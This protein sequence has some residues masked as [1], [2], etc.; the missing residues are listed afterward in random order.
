MLQGRK[1]GNSMENMQKWWSQMLDGLPSALRNSRCPKRWDSTVPI[2]Q[3][4]KC[5]IPIQTVR[6][7]S[8][9]IY[10]DE[11][12]CLSD[13]AQSKIVKS[14]SVDIYNSQGYFAVYSTF[15]LYV[16]R[17]S[18]CLLYQWVGCWLVTFWC[19]I[20]DFTV[21]TRTCQVEVL[22]DLTFGKCGVWWLKQVL[23]FLDSVIGGK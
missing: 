13:L 7:M 21:H 16:L 6:L 8:T 17:Y 19:K 3:L 11:P 10:K 15:E 14:I 12:T 22:N 2:Q 18:L 4:M 5:P 20:S 9:M 23:K 1:G